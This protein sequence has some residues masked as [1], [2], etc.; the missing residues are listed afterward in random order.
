M[1]SL[2]QPAKSRTPS[3]FPAENNQEADHVTHRVW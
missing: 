2:S 3:A 1:L